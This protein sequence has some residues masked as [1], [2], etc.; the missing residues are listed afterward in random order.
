MEAANLFSTRTSLPCPRCCHTRIFLL[1]GFRHRVDISHSF[2]SCANNQRQSIQTCGYSDEYLFTTARI[3]QYDCPIPAKHE[4]IHPKPTQA[5][6]PNRG[7]VNQSGAICAICVRGDK[8][9]AK[10]SPTARRGFYENNNLAQFM[11]F[12]TVIIDK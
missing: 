7:N 4:E 2:C 11:L 5:F 9:V 12:T 6:R 10:I 3:L 1:L 8:G